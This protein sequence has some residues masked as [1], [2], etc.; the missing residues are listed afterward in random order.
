ML[1]PSWMLPTTALAVVSGVIVVS[2]WFV[3]EAEHV[4][5]LYV[6]VVMLLFV[7]P[8]LEQGMKLIVLLSLSA[9]MLLLS[10]CSGL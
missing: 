7:L 2:L 8:V 1:A 3:E 10:V 6:R 5:L 9:V 4:V